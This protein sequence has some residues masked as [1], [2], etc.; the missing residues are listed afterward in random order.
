MG[1][2]VH[3]TGPATLKESFGGIFQEERRALNRELDEI[4]RGEGVRSS[5][6]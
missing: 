3:A 1:I 4:L 2:R 6:G 5:Y